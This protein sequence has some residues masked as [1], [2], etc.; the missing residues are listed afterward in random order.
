MNSKTMK[1]ILLLIAGVACFCGIADIAFG[2]AAGINVVAEE[3]KSNLI[4]VAK[5]ITAGSYV[6]GMA[7][8]VAAITKFKAHKDNPQQQHISQPIAYLFLSA[9]LL[10]IPNVFYSS[11]ATL[12]GTSGTQAGLS[13]ISSF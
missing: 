11:G 3:A 9:A 12:F 7:F 5:L 6:G 13:G 2:S 8:G 10:F 1:V 4:G